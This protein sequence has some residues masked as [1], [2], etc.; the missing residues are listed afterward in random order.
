M[1]HL[2]IDLG[3]RESQVCVR[4]PTGDILLERKVPTAKLPGFLAKQPH[5]RVIVETSAEAFMV[6]D[7]AAEHGHEV[8]V[9]PATLARTLGVGERRQKNDQRD[10][11]KLSEVSTR[12]DLPSVHVPSH[13]ARERKALCNSRKTL[14]AARTKLVNY[15]RGYLRARALIVRGRAR[16]IFASTVRA[17]LLSH[18]DGL[19]E[20]VDHVL[21]SIES[22]NEHIKSLDQD[23][24]DI[25]QRD[26]VCQRLMTIPGVGPVIATRFVSVVDQPERFQSAHHVMS[27]VGLT[28]GENSSSLRV[29]RTG[30]TKAGATDLRAALVQGAWTLMRYKSNDPMVVWALALAKRRN[31]FIAVTALA[32][33]L[34][35]LLWAI[36][37]QG[38]TYQPNRLAA[39]TTTEEVASM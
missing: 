36:W 1:Q 33:K 25:A 27:Y 34:T 22:L 20:H 3:S 9:V 7:A 6:A 29:Q 5:S 23:L 35:G 17:V 32:R 12:I 19:P 21:Q 2:A 15:V 14:L 30:I 37:T 18:D 39:A 10:A 4:G 31:R 24:L 26:P 11:R 28:P 16:P 38:T 13:K 8:R